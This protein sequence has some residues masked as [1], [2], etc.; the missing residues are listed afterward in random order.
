M[1]TV[2]LHYCWLCFLQSGRY[3]A[4]R[5]SIYVQTPTESFLLLQSSL[6][7][8]HVPLL[9]LCGYSQPMK[10]WCL[11]VALSSSS[12]SSARSETTCGSVRWA[13]WRHELGLYSSSPW[14]VGH[15]R[16]VIEQPA[17][18]VHWTVAET[19]VAIIF[20]V[21]HG[22]KNLLCRTLW[23]RW[24][25][26]GYDLSGLPGCFKVLKQQLDCGGDGVLMKQRCPLQLWCF[27]HCPVC[28]FVECG[29]VL[30]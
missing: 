18:C 17:Y 12:Y 13:S 8:S 19:I 27:W 6:I 24:C 14:V 25:C 20:A 26:Y 11:A 9:A 10:C 30:V 16:L 7:R 4:M 15:F 21:R 2:F 28:C 5:V 22:M 1:S 3:P 23:P 29:L